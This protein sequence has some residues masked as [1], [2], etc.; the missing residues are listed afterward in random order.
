MNTYRLSNISIADF[1]LF[2]ADKGCQQVETGNSGHEKWS[3]EGMLRP[4][5]FQ[6][7]IDPIPEFIIRN[8]LRNMELTTNDLRAWLKQRDTK[9]RLKK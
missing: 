5:V 3:K 4:V 8:N 9:I 1:R 6:T 2:L 7:H